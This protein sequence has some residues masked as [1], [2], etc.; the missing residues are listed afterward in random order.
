ML[1]LLLLLKRKLLCLA[2][3][4][5]CVGGT[6]TLQA[7]A[8]PNDSCGGAIPIVIGNGG[9]ALGLFT[10]TNTDITS[11][12]L[13]TGEAFAPSII[14]AGLNKKSVWYKFSL[15]TNR[16]V[17]VSL[18]QPGSAI[19]AGNVGFTI[20]KTK[21][22]LPGNADVSTKLS[23][24]ETFGNTFHP[25]VDVGDYLVQ[26]TS[27]NAAN[28]PVYITVETAEPTPADYDKPVNAY[29]FVDS[30]TFKTLIK[31]YF[32]QCQTIDNAAENCQPNGSF[33]NY[34]KS[35]W[36]TFTTPNYFDYLNFWL[37]IKPGNYGLPP[38][39]IGYRLYEGDA[40]TTAVA[41]LLPVGGCDSILTDLYSIGKKYYGCGMLKPNTKYSVQLLFHKDFNE[42]I[43]IAVEWNGSQ[44]TN[45]PLPVSSLAAP[46]KITTLNT[47]ATTGGAANLLTDYFGCNS[48]HSQ[49]NCPKSMPANGVLYNG[50]NYNLSSFFSF[51]L[52]TTT[53]LFFNPLNNPCSGRLLMRLYKQGL[54]NNCTDLDTANIIAI[55]DPNTYQINPLSCLAPGNYVLQVMGID[56]VAGINS[57]HISSL[58]NSP[59]NYLCRNLGLGS[60]F[61]FNMNARTE[62]AS[63]KFSLS[64]TGR[65]DKINV[66]GLGVMQ[67][68]QRGVTYTAT[69]DT[70]G[71]ANTV[72]PDDDLCQP[73]T[74]NNYTK[75]SYREFVVAD[76][77]ILYV[78]D[79]ISSASASKIFKGDLNAL[80]TSQSA[81]NYPQKITGVQPVSGCFSGYSF[82]T[83]N[84]CITPGTYTIANFD[85]R[86]GYEVTTKFTILKPTSKFN[87]PTT[88]Q[89]MG[90]I[91]QTIDPIYNSVVSA[92]DTFTC[93]DNPLII[94]GV[95]PCNAVWSVPTTKQIYRQFYLSKPA[96]VSIYNS[97][98]Y[99]SFA[100]RNT[101]FFGKATDGVA[102]L[103]KVGTKWTCFTNV[104]SSQCEALPAG[105]YTVV[106][107]GVG[108]N[109][110]NPLPGNPYNIQYSDAGLPNAF[111]IRLTVAC[112]EPKFNRPHKASIDTLT[113][114]PYK[115]EWGPQTGH[116]PAYP[117]TGKRYT[118]NVENFDC[119]QDTT[120][121]KT[122]M[123]QCSPEN[124][125]V[126]FYVFR[127]TQE[128]YVQVGALPYDFVVSM[129][130]F[131][132]R[133]GDS[134]RLKTDA[135]LQPCLTNGKVS[136]F[137]K[138]Q[139]GIYTMVIYGSAV[140][141]SSC[142][143]ITPT[144]YVDQVGQSRF[145]HA[146]KAYDFG[147]I[148][149]DSSWYNGKPGDV[150]P[151]NS[152][153]AA[154]NDFFY[155]T[156]GAQP[157]D[158]DLAACMSKYNANIYLPG[159]NIVLH[160]NNTTAPEQSIIDRRN[161]W[162]TFTVDHPG[163]IR[164]AVKNM[165]IG[166]NNS[167][168]HQYPFSVF[169][170]DVDGTL[171][172]TQVIANGLVDSTLL[173]GLSLVG[174]NWGMYNYCAG[175]PE[176]EVLVPPC[177]FTPT[178]YYV[179]VENR[180]PYGYDNVHSM[181]PNSQVE[182]SILLDSINANPPKFD[183]F[184][185][186]NDMG[187]VN[188]GIKKGAVDNF[189][190][191]T[192]DLTDP[193][194]Y[195]YVTGCNKTL[196]YKFTTT[197]TGQ[198][199]YAAFFKGTNYQYYD[200]IQ[201]FQQ[202]KPNDSSNTGLLSLI[203][204]SNYF[205]NGVWAQRCITPGTYYIILPGC[206]AVNEDVYP[207]IEII[208]QAGDFCSFPMI[209][210]L[211]GAGSKVVPVTVD[212]HTIG[213]DYGEFNPTL[214]CPAGAVTSN[215]KTS[216][217]RL[218][219]TGTDTLDVT[220][221]IDEKTNAGSTDIKYRMMTGTCGAMQ[222]QSCVQDALT[223][224]T[225]KCL[226]PGNSYFIQVFS[227]QTFN[228]TQVTGDIDLNIAAVVHADTCLPA[229]TCIG[230]ANFTPQFDCTKDKNVTFT[231]FSTYGSSIKYDWDFGYN[232]QKSTA[233]S[234]QFFY[235]ALTVSKTYTV[236]LVITNTLC[237][238]KDSVTQTITIPARPA[239][240]LGND[241]VICNNGSTIVLDA[242]SHTG[243]TY[244]WYNG[245][246]QPTFTASGIVSPYV[247]VTYNGCKTRDTINIKINPIAK[248]TLQTK[249]L[250]AV[251]QVS[252]DAYRGQGEQYQWSNGIFASSIMVSQPGIYWVDVYWNGC[253][254]RDSFQVVSTSLRPLG[255]DTTLC[256]S[257]SPYT[258]NAI[259]SGAT[260]Y[261]W[262]N[263]SSTPTFSINKAGVYWVDINLG[264]CTFRD[265]L[266]VGID[267]FKL[268]TTSARICQG[269][270]Y[271]LPTG[272]VINIAGVY[273]DSLKN[274]RGCD[275]LITTITLT[276]DTVK[277]VT[278]NVSLCVGQLYTFPGGTTIG[279][280]GKY[281]DTLKNTR[282]CDSLITT[283]NL[284]IATTVK[285]S[286]TATICNGAAYTLP[287]GKSVST[288]G[289]YI[290]TIKA[291]AGCDS[292]VTTVNLTILKPIINTTT[293]S[294]CFGQTYTLPNGT[295]VNT[296][297]VYSDTIR[298]TIGC[299]SLIR[300]VTVTVNSKPSLGS[301]KSI[302]I[303]PDNTANL[304]SQFTTTGLTSSW[305][306]GG[307]AV[308]TPTSVNTAGTYQLIATNSSGCAD[309][310]LI[311][312]TISPKPA[313]DADK[314]AIT[315]TGNIFD[316][317]TQFATTG[318]TTNWTLDGATVSN[319][320]AASIGGLYQLIA[321]NTSGC[322]DTAFFNLSVSPRP[323]LGADKSIGICEGTS[324]D[325]TVQ[326]SS[327]GLT[328][329]WTLGGVPVLNPAAVK[330]VGIYQLIAINAAGFSDTAFL[331]LFIN[332]NPT[333]GIDKIAAICAGNSF[334]LN[335]QFTTTGLTT[336]WTV[337]GAAIANANAVVTA[338]I[339]QLIV[340]NS[341]GCK[342]TATLPLTVNPKPAL[343]VDKTLGICEG[344]TAS[345]TAQF[346]TTGLTTNWSLNGGAVA[347]PS[348]VTTGGIY[349]LIA[350]NSNGCSD[351]S[352]VTLTVSPKP[353]LGADKSIAIC[354]GNLVNLT[355]QFTTT[356]LTTSWT[357]NGI[358]VS[359]PA[360][361]TAT[362]IYQLIA[363]SI[364]SC[365][366]TALV[367]IS[368]AP[369][370]NLGA[371]K[372][373]TICAGNT[374]NLTT[375]FT[376]TGL[377]TNWTISG[378]AVSTPSG[379]K[380]GGVYRL[381]GTNSNGCSDTALFNLTVNPSPLL[382]ADKTVSYCTGGSINL[383][384]QFVTTGL[385]S[386]WSLNGNTIASPTAITSAGV[387]RLI[388]A[389]NFG[390]TDTASVGVSINLLPT[391]LV[392]D[393]APVCTP[394]TINLT[395]ASVTAGST[396]GLSY[397]YWRD[398]A[399]T[400][401]VSNASAVP[402]GLY[403]IKGTDANGCFDSRPVTVT[404]YTLPVVNAGR[405]TAICDQSFAILSGTATNLGIGTVGYLWSPATGLSNAATARTTA[406]PG[407]ST[408]YRLTARVDYGNCV[409]SV[410]DNVRINM[411][412]PV[413]AF[414]GNDT[415]AVSGVPHQMRATGG[416]NYLWSPASVLNNASI[417]NPLATLRQ[418]T[419]FTVVVTDV[420]GCK[421]SATVL[422]K[423][424]N[425][426]TYYLPNAFSPN[427]DGLNEVFRPIPAGIVSTEYFRIFS[428][429]G[430]LIFETS[431]PLKGW[432]GFYKGI[433]QPIGNYI[434]SIKGMGSDGKVVEMK[435]NVVLV[436]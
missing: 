214:T 201:L 424:Y 49:N 103:K 64:A 65:F 53:S 307:G 363:T 186:A 284:T 206:N 137:C 180:N 237:G 102:Q 434:W 431:Q 238:K 202:I 229:A 192:K 114:Q 319:P 195:S 74:S 249:A 71:C 353:A 389:N 311:T 355:T 277:R 272:K 22:C 86:L 230:V 309:T 221:Y 286:T 168:T 383:T 268:V 236:K 141:S 199:R 200:H 368:V 290:D 390:C 55:F 367:T 120:F 241:T 411:Q 329:N 428:R 345:L 169:K 80:A 163:K 147:A 24:I 358:V 335:N 218:D 6:T 248:R 371:D 333:L 181:N 152:G 78:P 70:L 104:Y 387:Y 88:A 198:I 242:T 228:G 243:S 246:A 97:F 312:L 58:S 302:A 320:A 402:S 256:Q 327:I 360:A 308:A 73:G 9:F 37:V 279:I 375:Q 8:P 289:I 220:V 20:Y 46:N 239:V 412:P 167:S 149:P 44:V 391:V 354:A 287:S 418:D 1:Q 162:Y 318:F 45:G 326:F 263:N 160:P 23:P 5:M 187:L 394:A 32:V 60:F 365:K 133:R 116:T 364:A 42:E 373:L 158:P 314:A 159:N 296:A 266:T 344:N 34:T 12:T 408:T 330:A 172:F 227:P 322:S 315:Y 406:A 69:P 81:F 204:T 179:M 234:P 17:R 336:N 294:S 374:V 225:Y 340:T 413:V 212:C 203:Y 123:Q 185:Q 300:N 59:D 52:T 299:D 150:N 271:I 75:A 188:S 13:Q 105:W 273:K 83:Q 332:P 316:L 28:G 183:H 213:T 119:S 376:T 416:V 297:G 27:N 3:I 215:Y 233:V 331:T 245:S 351:T 54:T 85:N 121:I 30:K 262:Q 217:Y 33:V 139:P 433:R 110:A 366:D 392:A 63:N 379:V 436:R 260:S 403:Y 129:Y 395:A 175:T 117:V 68:L 359:N 235:P 62:V 118:L 223:R 15:P 250:C 4:A 301:D 369:K 112:P 298:Y 303:C 36:Q 82:S 207:Q 281:I 264:G 288:T 267:S 57:L 19:Q 156:T 384:S 99:L 232:N 388:V 370:P 154:S 56:S 143:P 79:Y 282:G 91:W 254:V 122:Y 151:L 171:Q 270:S 189:T 325:L 222:E 98:N 26:V 190:C 269:H 385:T 66:N 108:P 96:I 224:N 18:L 423:V 138:M 93:Y 306:L 409:L 432:D 51:N 130:D 11:A 43:R 25:C 178:R 293:V 132:V 427:G 29:D 72:L 90:D 257:N 193:L 47:S 285:N 109:F 128:S 124:V 274:S 184:S 372:A 399:A 39:K 95:N 142:L 205:D 140:Y 244:Y 87:A 176:I 404:V 421:A 280:A 381:I 134:T 350:A 258:A 247:E 400:I 398:M 135:A 136:E 401:A 275:S 380:Q 94:D 425:G 334:N 356:G 164:I 361:V 292:L 255:N 252:L 208:P 157:L 210:S 435:G 397:T 265:S 341:S 430:Q 393:P 348:A 261:T 38:V 405:D 174:K 420:A 155:C 131:D 161:L 304:T 92:V 219:I 148:K 194:N 291:L 101:L 211:T 240:N 50:Y 40:K 396:Q 407:A 362:G 196:W 417:V 107:Y 41:S 209:A 111:Q 321:T 48:R 310:A 125:K 191:A 357:N 31:D 76:S 21:N 166:K 278:N 165:T 197:V 352:L 145:D 61:K 386:T 422:V 317:T 126:S 113:G 259:V 7:A 337:N 283:L 35:T 324:A 182:V 146:A 170:S 106:S 77:V 14:V 429:Y 323:N 426:I 305:T 313:L 339:Y 84:A 343:G 328:G 419:W 153:R 231:N 377:T 295:K 67:P 415:V 216:W 115:I 177:S 144:I 276:V 127:L 378:A 349:Q 100:G 346:T 338:G 342:D 251:T 414:A 16:S 89:D 173:Q 410:A 347:N 253:I 382:G 10:S 226:A 2:I